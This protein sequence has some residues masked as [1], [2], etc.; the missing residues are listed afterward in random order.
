MT[1]PSWLA[2]AVVY[3][4]PATYGNKRAFVTKS[5]RAVVAER[6]T[7]GVR[8]WQDAIRSAM[9]ETAPA[10]PVLAPVNL[11]ILVYL[12]R[13][14]SHF[15][16][17]R[18]A[19]RLKDDAPRYPATRP[20]GDKVARAVADCGTGIW[21]GDDGQVAVWWVHKLW[22]DEGEPRTEV[23]FRVLSEPPA[24]AQM[25][26]PQPLELPLIWETEAARAAKKGV[27]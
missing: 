16:T 2:R 20:D 1:S 4:P 9:R 14:K 10:L 21:Y 13:P 26:L 11:C 19:R 15:G 12:A 3:G 5:G 8:Q 27:R 24:P 25:E 23:A 7:G 6:R 22:A 18:N 17:G